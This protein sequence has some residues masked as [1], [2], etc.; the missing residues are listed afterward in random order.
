M[1]K[2]DATRGVVAGVAVMLFAFIAMLVFVTSLSGDEVAQAEPTIVRVMEAGPDEYDSDY[3]PTPIK[4][5]GGYSWGDVI[6]FGDANP[7]YWELFERVTEGKDRDYALESY[8]W[9]KQGNNVILELLKGTVITNSEYLEETNT[10]RILRG[11][12]LR[13]DRDAIT[14]YDGIPRVLAVCLN[15]IKIEKAV[16]CS[17]KEPVPKPKPEPKPEPECELPGTS[18]KSTLGDRDN[19]ANQ[20]DGRDSQPA[21][22]S[23]KKPSPDGESHKEPIGD[24]THDEYIDG[25]GGGKAPPGSYNGGDEGVSD[26]T[27]TDD[28]GQISDGT[29]SEPSSPGS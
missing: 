23:E 6:L 12:V 10:Y 16:P 29:V 5:G 4:P 27:D 22:G 17:P 14:G 3:E 20:D 26:P 28:T 9:E 7:G 19:P 21:D 24:G 8:K 25:T 15:P 18:P 13:R 11:Y 1:S 2:K